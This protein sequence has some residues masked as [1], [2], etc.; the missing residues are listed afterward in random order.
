MKQI[1]SY[2]SSK[3]QNMIF[4]NH[5]TVQI[6]FACSYYIMH[7]IVNILSCIVLG[8]EMFWI[9]QGQKHHML[10]LL[11]LQFIWYWVVAKNGFG[12]WR[13]LRNE[14]RRMT[15]IRRNRGKYAKF[16]KERQT[17]CWSSE[18]GQLQKYY[19]VR[20]LKPSEMKLSG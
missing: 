10:P 3:W 13:A 5:R 2:I 1:A 19:R 20:D 8:D 15:Q 7:R 18:R 14:G 6:K 12:S 17:C 4:C 16:N 11:F 9:W